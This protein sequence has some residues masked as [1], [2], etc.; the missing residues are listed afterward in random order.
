MNQPSRPFPLPSD[1]VERP[2]PSVYLARAAT[3][4]L[5]SFI[6]GAKP[7]SI[8]KSMWGDDH[9][10]GIILKATTG[11]ATTTGSNWAS[12]LAGI[13]IYDTIQSITSISAAAE[14]IDRGLK[15]NMD[16]IGELRVPG[17]VLNAAAAGQW[18][19]EGAPIPARALSFSNATILRPRK[20]SVLTS[21]TREMIESSNIEAVVKATLAEAAGLALDIRM[22][23]NTA[24]DAAG[25]G[26]LFAGVTPLVPTTGGGATPGEA[27]VTD[28]GNLFA[29]LA[30]NGAGKTAVIVAAVPQATRLKLVAG[31][32]FDTDIIASTA[33]PAGTVAAIELAS[34]VSGFSSVPEFETARDAAIH[35]EDTSPQDI[36]GGTPSP[37]VPIKSMFQ[38]DATALR[39]S[40][41]GAWGLRAAGHAQW[42]Q[43]ATW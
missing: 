3:A 6:T 41:W 35:M 30:A 11:P 16:H 24:A 10:T 34:F 38:L 5:R 14:L 39:L 43:G 13:A 22:F 23:S 37:A 20:L 32:Q 12:A 27:A 31:A 26:G 15:L 2:P 42:I 8:A 36:T 25:P 17:R 9:V 1:L 19:A 40:L 28:I 7:A 29:A 18:V 33:L 21:Y 4:H